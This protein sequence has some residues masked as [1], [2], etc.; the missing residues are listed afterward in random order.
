MASPVTDIYV[1]QILEK[2][3]P[4]EDKN[5]ASDRE[6]FQNFSSRLCKLCTLVHLWKVVTHFCGDMNMEQ[7]NHYIQQ[8][9]S[10]PLDQIEPSVVLWGGP[11]DLDHKAW[12]FD[13]EPKIRNDPSHEQHEQYQTILR[14]YREF[15]KDQLFSDDVHEEIVPV[16]KPSKSYYCSCWCWR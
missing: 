16:E 4:P 2:L 11:A 3:Y 12:P 1:Y 14:L 5:I 6:R 8:F 15:Y 9:S 7:A 13:F 10:I